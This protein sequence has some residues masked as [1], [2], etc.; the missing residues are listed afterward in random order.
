MTSQQIRERSSARKVLAVLVGLL[1]TLLALEGFATVRSGGGFQAF[2]QATG[3]VGTIK[4]V[5]PDTST[6]NVISAESDTVDTAYHLVAWVA[7]APSGAVVQFKYDSDAE[8]TPEVNINCIETNSPNARFVSPDTYECHWNLTGI[9]D[10][11]S[12]TLRAVLY[13][14][15]GTQSSQDSE[16]VTIDH[17][18]QTVEIVYPTQAGRVGFYT[19]S[20][21]VATAMIDVRSSAAEPASEDAVTGTEVHERVDVYYS[22][23]PPGAEPDFVLCGSGEVDGGTQESIRCDIADNPET[24]GRENDPTRVTAIA[25][26]PVHVEDGPV[27]PAGD[28]PD[29]D[30]SEDAGAADA[31][32]AFGYEQDPT[33]VTI[34]NQTQTKDVGTCSN[35]I[36]ATVRDAEGR[37]VVGVNMDVHA[38]GPTDN[39]FF[40]DSDASDDGTSTSQAPENHQLESGADC[41]DTE[42]PVAFTG[43]QQGQ[44][45]QVGPDVKHIESP[46]EDGGTDENG[47]F[48]FQLYSL[49]AGTT[50]YTVWAD[51]DGDDAFC[52][53]EAH[54]DGSIGWGQAAPSPTGVESEPCPSPT[55][56]V[57]PTGTATTTPT[58][59]A[60]ATSTATSTTTQPPTQC[61]DGQDN[62]GDGDTD[63]NDQGCDSPQD[64]DESD[65]GGDEVQTGPCAGYR[66]GSRQ[67]QS[68]G[69]GLVI[70]G[71]NGP[72]DLRGDSQDDLICG[73]G[74]R[75]AIRGRSG[76]DRLYGG[77]GHDDIRGNAGGDQIYGQGGLDVL[78]GGGGDDTIRG[79]AQDDTMRGYIGQDLLIGGAGDDSARAGRHNDVLRG[80]SGRDLLDGGRGR[81]RCNGGR[82]NDTQANCER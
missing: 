80:N 62:D 42:P 48:S 50:Q 1:A 9:E 14:D 72:D 51:E 22:A 12:G 49:D 24:A 45:D 2:A 54:A 3:G 60:T 57:S 82:G 23:A 37:Q 18:A 16:T 4:L 79:G 13:N 77:G 30:F 15:A 11:D 75:D 27:E 66:E 33:T 39:L 74:G 26:V 21:G 73:L 25:A 28:L 41:E 44:H 69:T 81:D 59:T 43:E 6:S 5:N 31:H 56:T 65:E 67:P 35:V 61:S 68:D 63:M 20:D 70:V 46:P 19:G 55:G 71:T 8:N 40:D 53:A 29:P 58:Q 34:T 7:N 36:T 32:R 10:G 38:M 64:N 17:T 47:N 76:N 78:R 52:S